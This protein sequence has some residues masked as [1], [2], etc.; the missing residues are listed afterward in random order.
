MK[1]LS[2]T[3][4]IARLHEDSNAAIAKG[5]GVGVSSRVWVP[6]KTRLQQIPPT[7][8]TTTRPRARKRYHDHHNRHLLTPAVSVLCRGVI[9]QDLLSVEGLS[10]HMPDEAEDPRSKPYVLRTFAKAKGRAPHTV[11]YK[12]RA[13]H[14]VAY[15][16][17]APHAVGILA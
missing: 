4:G 9:M 8:T 14:A 3:Y 10:K 16:R 11:A 5:G 12:K 7:S 15:K 6:W 17:R 13:P 1:G 2:K